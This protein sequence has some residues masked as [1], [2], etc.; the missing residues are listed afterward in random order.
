MSRAIRHL[1]IGGLIM[2]MGVS[3][4]TAANES[5]RKLTIVNPKNLYDP[6]P[7]GYSTAVVVPREAR[8][9]FLLGGIVVRA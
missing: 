8:E 6:T 4:A 7:N 1:L 2:T 5:D 9:K 3:A